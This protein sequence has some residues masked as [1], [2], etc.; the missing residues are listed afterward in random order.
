MGLF[1]GKKACDDGNQLPGRLLD[2]L[3]VA[4]C[5][6]GFVQAGQE[7]RDDANEDN[8][9]GCVEGCRVARCGDGF[10]RLDARL[11]MTATK[12]TPARAWAAGSPLRRRLCSGGSRGLRLRQR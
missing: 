5:G 12:T 3:C 10:C 6:D 7:G 9:D 11:V 2:D 8:T 4:R 1:G